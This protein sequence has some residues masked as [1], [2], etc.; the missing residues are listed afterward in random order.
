MLDCYVNA[1]VI[2][3]P[4][5]LDR[6]L[7]HLNLYHV[8]IL[9]ALG[10]P[11]VMGGAK[12]IDD[13]ALAVWVCS[14][15]PEEIRRGLASRKMQ[16]QLWLMGVIHR[17]DDINAEG[18]RFRRYMDEYMRMPEWWTSD[19]APRRVPWFF[20]V[21]WAIMPKVGEDRAWSMP[22]P[23]AMAYYATEADAMGSRS[24]MTEEELAAEKA[25]SEATNGSCEDTSPPRT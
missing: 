22:I 15:S 9:D 4:V 12:T 23:L 19:G 18:V 13:L 11:Y 6:R 21:A 25:L 8:A 16:R 7:N 1:L 5:V 2:S 24:V 10:S 14:R 17:D 3:P 20:G